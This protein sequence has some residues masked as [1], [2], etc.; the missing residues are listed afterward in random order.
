MPK[1]SDKEKM[2]PKE[3]LDFARQKGWQVLS[4]ADRYAFYND[5]H[6]FK[7]EYIES[8]DPEVLGWK[9][10]QLAKGTCG[11]FVEAHDVGYAMS[12]IYVEKYLREGLVG[13]AKNGPEYGS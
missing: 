4:E 9:F 13:Y 2:I 11:R 12:M 8:D 3:L 6:M 5:K 7:L 10:T 1:C